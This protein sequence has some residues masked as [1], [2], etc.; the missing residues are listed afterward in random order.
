MFE[1]RDHDH[2]GGRVSGPSPEHPALA[3]SP[4]PWGNG[5]LALLAAVEGAAAAWWVYSQFEGSIVNAALQSGVYGLLGF[6]NAGIALGCVVLYMLLV[7]V[8]VQSRGLRWC[9]FALAAFLWG[10]CLYRLAL[11]LSGDKDIALGGF[12][13]GAVFGF[14]EKVLVSFLVI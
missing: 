7:A 2:L 12:A 10:Y 14:G 11:N 6:I 5:P 13:V 8:A 3:E 9:A 4:N 1:F